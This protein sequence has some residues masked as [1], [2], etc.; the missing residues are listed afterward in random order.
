MTR[1][2]CKT[3][4][5]QAHTKIER[6][7]C[8]YWYLAHL[9]TS[10]FCFLHYTY[11]CGCFSWKYYFNALTSSCTCGCRVLGAGHNELCIGNISAK[12]ISILKFIM[13]MNHLYLSISAWYTTALCTCVNHIGNSLQSSF[14]VLLHMYSEKYT[15]VYTWW[16]CSRNQT[17]VQN[18]WI[19][20]LT[21]C[22]AREFFS[23]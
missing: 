23:L 12:I 21:T 5:Y 2:C 4:L 14:T 3:L 11:W 10:M 17:N 18:C 22:N 6:W 19:K 1:V 7:L 15:R 8:E 13:D 9:A 20:V 16:C